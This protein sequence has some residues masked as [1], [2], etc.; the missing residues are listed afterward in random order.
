MIINVRTLP[1]LD[2]ASPHPSALAT[3]WTTNSNLRRH[4]RRCS[5]SAISPARMVLATDSVVDTDTAIVDAPVQSWKPPWDRRRETSG[6]LT[7]VQYDTGAM[8]AFFE[9][10]PERASARF[11]Q[12]PSIRTCTRFAQ[13]PSILTRTYVLCTTD[14]YISL[15]KQTTSYS[16]IRDQR[17]LGHVSSL[18]AWGVESLCSSRSGNRPRLFPMLYH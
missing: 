17:H 14:I 3:R 10:R 5:P 8:E 15:L 13:V 4:C 18:R 2:V 1:S 11:A 12:V 7:G 16:S 6:M 9:H